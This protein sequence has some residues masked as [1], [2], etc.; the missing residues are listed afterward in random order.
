MVDKYDIIIR[1]H[2]TQGVALGYWLL[3]LRGVNDTLAKLNN[4]YSL[5]F[6]SL[7]I[8]SCLSLGVGVYWKNSME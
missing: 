1:D 3:P 2:V 4:N 8:S 6:L 5:L 7:T